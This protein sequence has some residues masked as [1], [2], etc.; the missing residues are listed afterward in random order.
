MK[1]TTQKASVAVSSTY[2]L[3]HIPGD[4]N[5]IFIDIALDNRKRRIIKI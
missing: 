4:A 5:S 1:R 2:P 3:R